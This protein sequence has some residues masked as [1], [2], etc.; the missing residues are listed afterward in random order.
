MVER[1]KAIYF[2]YTPDTAKPLGGGPSGWGAASVIHAID[3]GLAGIRDADKGYAVIDFSPRWP[4]TEYTE[5]RYVTGYER[6]GK[7]VDCRYILTEKGLRYRLES[8]ARRVNAH[9]LLPK[10]R[11]VAGFYVNGEKTEGFEIENIAD[12]VYLN[13]RGASG[14]AVDF[15]ILFAE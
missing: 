5:L 3:E 11:R 9:V 1:D 10:G 8:P 15:E 4:V 6:A 12:S 7:F 13:W 2:L 14:K